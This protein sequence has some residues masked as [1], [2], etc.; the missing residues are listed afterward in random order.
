MA[1]ADRAPIPA[2]PRK[3]LLEWIDHDDGDTTGTTRPA[4]SG[5]LQAL[6]AQLP[7]ATDYYRAFVEPLQPPRGLA[8]AP[9]G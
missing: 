3:T 1:K 6:H 7:L 9:L 5:D 8:L 4:C 2:A